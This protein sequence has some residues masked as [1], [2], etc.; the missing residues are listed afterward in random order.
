[1]KVGEIELLAWAGRRSG[2]AAADWPVETSAADCIPM[3]PISG[4]R[5]WSDTCL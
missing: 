5:R 4:S 2:E 1:M 3:W